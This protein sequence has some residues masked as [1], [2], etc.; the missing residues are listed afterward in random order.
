MMATP[1]T[2]HCQHPQSPAPCLCAWPGITPAEYQE[3]LER[4]RVQHVE[5]WERGAAMSDDPEG[6][7]AMAAEFRECP[8]WRFWADGD[9][10]IVPRPVEYPVEPLEAREARR[11]RIHASRVRRLQQAQQ[12]VD[13]YEATH[14][15][16][17]GVRRGQS[18]AS[19]NWRHRQAAVDADI[20]A[21]RRYRQAQQTVREMRR[22]LDKEKES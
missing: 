10:D 17:G 18:V 13:T 6:A 8:A 12:V 21:D 5:A 19:N 20:A 15:V 16:V 1:R 11:A 9:P 2:D 4:R 3:L 22:L 14:P 7:L